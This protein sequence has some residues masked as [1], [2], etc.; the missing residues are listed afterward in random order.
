VLNLGPDN[1]G[2]LNMGYHVNPIPRGEFGEVDKIA[3]EAIEFL[4]AIEQGVDVMALVELADL[5]GAMEGYL[6][7]H[8]PTITMEDLSKMSKVTA[9]AFQDGTRKPRD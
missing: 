1:E 8:H 7:K 4:D 9:R 5:Y 2:A 3:E 6:E